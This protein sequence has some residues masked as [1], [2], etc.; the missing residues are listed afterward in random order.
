M[1]IIKSRYLSWDKILLGLGAKLLPTCHPSPRTKPS[2]PDA[3]PPREK[4]RRRVR[5]TQWGDNHDKEAGGECVFFSNLGC[6]QAPFHHAPTYRRVQGNNIRGPIIVWNLSGCALKSPLILLYQYKYSPPRTLPG[7]CPP[8]WNN[9]RGLGGKK[10]AGWRTLPL[11]AGYLL[12]R[13]LSP[14]GRGGFK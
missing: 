7:S 5:R 12:K 4:S 6:W 13:R 14:R 2:N 8:S 3:H 9:L 11:Q 10:V 1:E